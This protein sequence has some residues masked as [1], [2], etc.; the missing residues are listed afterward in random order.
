M[1]IANHNGLLSATYEST[2]TLERSSSSD[3]RTI[4]G[5][6]AP[7]GVETA[8]FVVEQGIPYRELF[9]PGAFAKTIAERSKKVKLRIQH[10]KHALDTIGTATWLKEGSDGLV[11]GFH[12]SR[13]Q[14]GDEV[15]ELVRDGALDAL[16][17]GFRP[18]RPGPNER[19]AAGSL[20]ERHE[21]ALTEVSLVGEGAYEDARVL[22]VR[23]LEAQERQDEEAP[24]PPSRLAYWQRKARLF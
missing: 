9:R 10:G 21:V 14:L 24:T 16:S 19:I 20:V 12:V 11:A 2:F 15:L 22:S 3:G 18:I 17:V 13:T 6:C 1:I 8:G 7:F 23:A 5:L 4:V